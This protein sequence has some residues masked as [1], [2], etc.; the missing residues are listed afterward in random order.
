MLI[1]VCDYAHTYMF[2][3]LKGG[4]VAALFCI[5]MDVNVF[6]VRKLLVMSAAH[7]ILFLMVLQW[8]IEIS[9]AEI[10]TYGSQ[11]CAGLV[12]ASSQDLKKHY[13]LATPSRVVQNEILFHHSICLLT[14]Q[15]WS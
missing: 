11:Y 9:M 4:A 6:S 5:R 14:V 8:G 15:I 2:G 12:G 7:G 3:F 13:R 10:H 1:R